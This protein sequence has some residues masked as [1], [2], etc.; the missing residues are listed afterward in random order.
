MAKAVK[1]IDVSNIPELLRIA[2]EVHAT[3]EPRVLRRDNEDIALL[4]PLK[5]VSKPMIKRAKGTAAYK[6][7]RAAAGGWK[8]VDTDRL[9]EEIYRDR[10]AGDRP[11]IEL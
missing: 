4:A 11:H 6:A 8:D 5:P 10:D 2:E 7:F 9:V 3:N 1:H